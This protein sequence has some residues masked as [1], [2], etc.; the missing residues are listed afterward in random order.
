MSQRRNQICTNS[1]PDY[2]RRLMQYMLA[3]TPDPNSD[4]NSD[5]RCKNYNYDHER[6]FERRLGDMMARTLFISRLLDV[7]VDLRE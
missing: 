2:S 7:A 1:A 5:G 4:S 3:V 6:P